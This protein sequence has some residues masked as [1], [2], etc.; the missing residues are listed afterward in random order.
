MAPEILDPYLSHTV[1]HQDRAA[2]FRSACASQVITP[3][4]RSQSHFQ[5]VHKCSTRLTVSHDHHTVAPYDDTCSTVILQLAAMP[6]SGK[7]KPVSENA[8]LVVCNSSLVIVQN[9]RCSHQS[10]ATCFCTAYWSPAVNNNG[11]QLTAHMYVHST[12]FMIAADAG[13]MR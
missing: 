10:V 2:F 6:N 11:S 7:G 12:T 4:T 3:Y 1:R 9:S 13:R 8:L 5:P